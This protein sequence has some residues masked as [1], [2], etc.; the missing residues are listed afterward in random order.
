MGVHLATKVTIHHVNLG[1]VHETHGLDI[2]G[3]L[4]ELDTGECTGGDETG[5]V[6]GLC[7]P[8]NHLALDFTDGLPWLARSPEAE[9]FEKFSLEE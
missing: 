6:A 9:V 8:C 7:A 5:T 4:Q 3:R 1:L 2:I